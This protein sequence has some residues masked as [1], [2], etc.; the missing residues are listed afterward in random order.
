MKLFKYVA[1]MCAAS[2]VLAGCASWL[3]GPGA[4]QGEIPPRLI[5]SNDAKTWDNPAAFG[6]VPDELK[7]VGQAVCDRLNTK[8]AQYKATGY[9]RLAKN[10][11]GKTLPGGGYYCVEK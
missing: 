2:A 9:H 10:L 3:P 7:A 8:E 5:I 1:L 4:K 11:N 6:Q